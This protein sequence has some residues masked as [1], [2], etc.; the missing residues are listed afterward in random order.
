MMNQENGVNTFGENMSKALFPLLI[1][2]VVVPSA[3]AA[4]AHASSCVGA[5]SYIHLP[6]GKCHNLSYMTMLSTSRA[7]RA[8]AAQMYQVMV[9]ANES[10]Y[11]SLTQAQ[12][13]ED[14]T[15]IQTVTTASSPTY[16]EQQRR[17]KL[18]ADARRNLVGATSMN[19]RIENMA[20]REHLRTL[21]VVSK[22]F[23][24]P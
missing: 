18:L 4:P 1:G 11:Q 8:Q 14:R 19:E 5:V 17:Q 21:N 7:N 13:T 20:W 3:I 23:A 22:A 16:L 6:N 9:E 2:A 15:T 24:H 10:R 12:S